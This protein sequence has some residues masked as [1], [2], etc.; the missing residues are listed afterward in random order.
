MLPLLSLQGTILIS[1]S[2][3]LDDKCN[4]CWEFWADVCPLYITGASMR[5]G[6]RATIYINSAMQTAAIEEIDGRV[7][8]VL[9]WRHSSAGM[10]T[11][12]YWHGDSQVHNSDVFSFSQDSLEA[13]ERANVRFRFLKHPEFLRVGSRVLFREGR[14]KGIGQITQLGPVE[15]A[16]DERTHPVAYSKPN[17]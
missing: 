6:F 11:L 2:L 8:R 7:S 3:P 17:R 13:G 12:Q 9:A 1:P 4:S 10:G 14:T 16:A 15:W 5:S